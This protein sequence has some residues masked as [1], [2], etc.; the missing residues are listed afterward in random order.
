MIFEIGIALLGIV[1]GWVLSL[2]AP[3]ELDDGK[4]YFVWG[5]RLLF[6]GML[7]VGGWLLFD[8]L[9]FMILFLLVGIVVLVLLMRKRNVKMSLIPYL[10]IIPMLFYSYSNLLAVL[11]F[12]YG[13]PVGLLFHETYKKRS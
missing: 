12:L 6:I 11:L 8:G 4:K 1:V 5:L 3:E 2:I 13:F 10:L 9:L 7:A